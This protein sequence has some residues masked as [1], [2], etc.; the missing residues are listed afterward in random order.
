MA[1]RPPNLTY[2]VEDKPPLGTSILLGVQHVFVISVGWVFV[3]V[4]ATGMGGTPAQAEQVIQFSMLAS[5]VATI[6]QARPNST[7]GSGYLCPISCGPAYISASI[8]AGKAGGFP[9]DR[10]LR[11][12]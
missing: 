8:F 1:K 2:G 11:P 6:L 7:L 10:N 4:I 9:L 12:L 5:G 3:I